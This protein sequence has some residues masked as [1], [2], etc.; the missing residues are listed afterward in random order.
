VTAPPSNPVSSPSGSSTPPIV[1][2][3]IRADD[4]QA[5]RDGTDRLSERSRYRRFLSPHSSLTPAELT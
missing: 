2:R 3:A 5:L 4:K 1:I